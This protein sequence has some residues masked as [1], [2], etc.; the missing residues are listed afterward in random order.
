MD[1]SGPA[2]CQG[3]SLTCAEDLPLGLWQSEGV[4]EVFGQ[5]TVPALM[6]A[7]QLLAVV[8]AVD[9]GHHRL[10][11]DLTQV[12]CEKPQEKEYSLRFG[13]WGH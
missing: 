10:E 1:R 13:D 2:C 5:E 7:L 8:E 3:H 6:V 12:G 9:D 4:V 11:G